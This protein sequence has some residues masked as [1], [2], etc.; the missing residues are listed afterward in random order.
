MLSSS[1]SPPSFSPFLSLPHPSFIAFCSNSGVTSCRKSYG[2]WLKSDLKQSQ[3][4]SQTARAFLITVTQEHNCLCFIS[5]HWQPCALLSFSPPILHIF[6]SPHPLISLS[7]WV[8]QILFARSKWLCVQR[9][10]E[11]RNVWE[12]E[13][14]ESQRDGGGAEWSRAVVMSH[15]LQADRMAEESWHVPRTQE[16]R[17]DREKTKCVWRKKIFY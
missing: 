16:E 3:D 1:H 14:L 12:T 17:E 10:R 2:S 11:R 4:G 8:S 15:L 9:Q 13:M 6:S 7:W 5:L